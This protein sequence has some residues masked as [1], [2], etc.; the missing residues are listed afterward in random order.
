MCN[1]GDGAVSMKEQHFTPGPR[2]T[3]DRVRHPTAGEGRAVYNHGPA[4]FLPDEGEPIPMRSIGLGGAQSKPTHYSYRDAVT[5]AGERVEL[6]TTGRQRGEHHS[7]RW[8]PIF[9]AGWLVSEAGHPWREGMSPSEEAR[10]HASQG[11]MRFE[12]DDGSP[13]FRWHEPPEE[14]AVEQSG[15]QALPMGTP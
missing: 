3:I 14:T 6:E 13:P 9:G 1:R 15:Q 4:F 2:Q 11:W 7:R 10:Y 12:P 8:S 5:M